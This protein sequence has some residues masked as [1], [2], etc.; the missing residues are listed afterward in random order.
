MSEDRRIK[1][2]KENIKNTLIKMLESMP[3]TSVS[4]TELAEKANISRKTFYLHYNSVYDAV[5]DIDN[6]LSDLLQNLVDRMER[7]QEKIDASQFFNELSEGIKHHKELVEYFVFSS[8]HSALKEKVSKILKNALLERIE[9]YD[10]KQDNEYIAEFLVGG[11]ISTFT[12]WY[13]NQTISNEELMDI[14]TKFC[15]LA[16]GLI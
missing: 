8:N 14:L 12:H 11:I 3:I 1:R 16:K 15:N 7:D 6:D 5:E 13:K 2:T 4:V 10:P 9:S